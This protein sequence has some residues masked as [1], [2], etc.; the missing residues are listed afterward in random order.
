MKR[1]LLLPYCFA[2]LT[3][4]GCSMAP[5]QQ[6]PE[7]TTK[8]ADSPAKERPQAAKPP[9]PK[10][11]PSPSELL[12]ASLYQ[13]HQEWKGIPYRLGG[14]SRRGIDCSA[15]VYLIYRDEMGI[16]LPRTTQYQA[17]AGKAIKR[18]QLRPG[19]LVFFRT[20]RRGRHVG[21][22]I[23]DGKFLHASVSKGVTISHMADYYWKSRYWR[24]RRLELESGGKS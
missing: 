6:S 15:L 22:Y 3:T 4:A 21:I 10:P 5:Y 11:T 20:G 16:Q 19:D 13:Q 23:E 7:D 9:K 1:R 2:M 24:A 12:K 8:A 17:V 14:M 18:G